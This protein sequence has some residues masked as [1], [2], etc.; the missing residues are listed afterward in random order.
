MYAAEGFN[1]DVSVSGTAYNAELVDVW[2]DWTHPDG[3]DADP[4]DW[5][6]SD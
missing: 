5:T 2:D 6:V 4:I 3:P 1:P